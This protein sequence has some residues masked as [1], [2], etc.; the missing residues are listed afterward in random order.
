MIKINM[1]DKLNNES[2]SKN[3]IADDIIKTISEISK[4]NQSEIS[5]NTLIR[6]ELNIDS[7]M[8]IEILSTIEIKYK[9]R[10]KEEKVIKMKR[11]G[12]FI[13]LVCFLLKKKGL[14][15]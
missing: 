4:I 8:A 5:N 6:E 1:K 9:I 7:L 10:I 13:E 15:K 2:G 11:V 14:G 3:D 12:E